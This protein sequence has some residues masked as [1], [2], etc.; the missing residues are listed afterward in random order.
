MPN[1]STEFYADDR[2]AAWL[3]PEAVQWYFNYLTDIF[4]KVEWESNTTKIK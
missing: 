4:E 1:V 3:H 2:V